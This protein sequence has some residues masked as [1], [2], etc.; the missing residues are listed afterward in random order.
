MSGLGRR[1]RGGVIIVCS[2]R[3]IVPCPSSFTNDDDHGSNGSIGECTLH[4]GLLFRNVHQSS[5]VCDL[6]EESRFDFVP[7]IEF[8]GESLFRKQ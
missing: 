4:A 3:H 8:T 2:T 5:S 7:F 6:P 1:S